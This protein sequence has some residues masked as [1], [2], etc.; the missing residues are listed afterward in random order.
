MVAEQGNEIMYR[1]C[2][3]CG[4]S[5]RWKPSAFLIC[6]DCYNRRHE[7][8]VPE[9]Q[10]GWEPCPTQP[11]KSTPPRPDGPPPDPQP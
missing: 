1:P 11:P 6:H 5:I 10:E 4:K 8:F 3:G 2:D 7:I 9:F